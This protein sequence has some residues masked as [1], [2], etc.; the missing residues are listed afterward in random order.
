M[1]VV[2][3]KFEQLAALINHGSPQKEAAALVGHA[4]ETFRNYC[5]RNGIEMPRYKTELLGDKIRSSL[6]EDV[7]AGMNGHQI[8][9]KYNCT[10]PFVS[11]IAKELGIKLNR[12]GGVS[13]D[14]LAQQVLDRVME[15][16]GSYVDVLKDMGLP[17]AP[18]TVRLYAQRVGFD[19]SHYR[20]A[21]RS[22]GQWLTLPGPTQRIYKADRLIPVTCT[23]CGTITTAALTNLHSG[24]SLCCSSCARSSQEQHRVKC[25]E[26]GERFTSIS[27]FTKA[28][29]LCCW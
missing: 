3:G 9:R 8:A 4:L 25:H 1:K 13:K 22:Y 28:L 12:P 10:P 5:K 16:G 20:F 24:S 18:I 19:F 21:H 26:T 23:G 14:N 2:P 29:G 27:A 6:R 7:A 11:T 17:I 15:V